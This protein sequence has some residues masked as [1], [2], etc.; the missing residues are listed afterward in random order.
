MFRSCSRAEVLMVLACLT[1]CAPATGSPDGTGSAP[2]SGGATPLGT[3]GVGSSGGS[4]GSPF[5]G[6]GSSPPITIDPGPGTGTGGSDAG[7]GT[8]GGYVPLSAEQ[9]ATIKGTQC[10][11]DTAIVEPLPAVL[12]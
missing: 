4:G 5:L 3:G 2:G 1:G 9:V 6:G 8:N 12:E 7:L 11:G 10:D